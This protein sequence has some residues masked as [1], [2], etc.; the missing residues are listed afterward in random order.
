MEMFSEALSSS[1]LDGRGG[2]QKLF[3]IFM[4]IRDQGHFWRLAF[5]S[6]APAMQ[7]ILRRNPAPRFHPVE[8][9]FKRMI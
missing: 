4:S 1:D 3:N 2:S 5:P 6:V 7:Q 9:F 8:Y